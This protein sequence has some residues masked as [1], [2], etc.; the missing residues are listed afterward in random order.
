VRER[1]LDE[2]Y[3]KLGLD[4]TSSGAQEEEE[5]PE[6]RPMEPAEQIL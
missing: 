4:Q 1:I 2:V 3:E 5:S 6:Q